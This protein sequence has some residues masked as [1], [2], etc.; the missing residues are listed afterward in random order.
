MIVISNEQKELLMEHL[1]NAEEILKTND[2]N[3]I[4]FP[5]DDLITEVGFDENYAL[6][7]IGSKL[8]RTYDQLFNQN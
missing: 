2:V 4:L 8:Q 5:L 6:N 3:D 1:P 7:N